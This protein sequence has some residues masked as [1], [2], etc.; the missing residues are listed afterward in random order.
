M[1]KQEAI[2]YLRRELPGGSRVYTLSF[3][4]GPGHRVL[5]AR[6]TGGHCDIMDVTPAVAKAT[7]HRFNPKHSYIS[8]PGTGFSKA[9]A[10]VSDLEAV[11][12]PDTP[13][14]ENLLHER[15]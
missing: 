15:L 1:T 7:G 11:L 13:Q 14:M 4:S 3:P 2:E 10:L 9:A 8:I 6:W 12:F 5:I